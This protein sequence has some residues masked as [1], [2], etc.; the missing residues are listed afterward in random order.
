MCVDAFPSVVSTEKTRRLSGASRNALTKAMTA[1]K[2][3]EEAGKMAGTGR[4]GRAPDLLRADISQFGTSI[5]TK[6][7]RNAL[8]SLVGM[9]RDLT[10]RVEFLMTNIATTDQR[11]LFRGVSR[12]ALRRKPREKNV[13]KLHSR[14]IV[15]E[16]AGCPWK[17][18]KDR[19]GLAP[20]RHILSRRERSSLITKCGRNSL[21]AGSVFGKAMLS[22][23]EQC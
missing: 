16:R 9:S 5:R 17:M 1:V 6:F 23:T 2:F 3:S 14:L 22:R 10:K 7:G 8:I 13:V 19:A 4:A 12:N 21:A 11:G 15:G 18:T 20:N